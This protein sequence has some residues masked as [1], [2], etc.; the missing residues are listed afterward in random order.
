MGP[1]VQR[2]YEHL[3]ACELVSPCV[4]VSED[5]SGQLLGTIIGRT[6]DEASDLTSPRASVGMSET[7]LSVIAGLAPQRIRLVAL[8]LP[9]DEAPAPTSNSYGST[10]WQERDLCHRANV[11]IVD[12]QAKMQEISHYCMVIPTV[13]SP[14]GLPIVPSIDPAF[15]RDRPWLNVL[16]APEDRADDA[17]MAVPVSCSPAFPFHVAAALASLTAGWIGMAID[18]FDSWSESPLTTGTASQRRLVVMRSR[19]RS[20]V[21]PS[22]ADT[23]P[24]AAL[25]K[26]SS[27]PIPRGTTPAIAPAGIT[28]R[29]SEIF[30]EKPGSAF[31]VQ[32][33]DR[34]PAPK[35]KSIKWWQLFQIVWEWIRTRA[36]E[37]A[38]DAVRRK[39]NQ[40]KDSIEDRIQNLVFGENS[41][42]RLDNRG[43]FSGEDGEF[44]EYDI[45]ARLADI[46]GDDLLLRSQGINP[47]V[48]AA[49]REWSFGL[50]DGGNFA[51]EVV[52][53]L[54]D[55][56]RRIVVTDPAFISPSPDD[57]GWWSPP[58]AVARLLG[59]AALSI[60][61]CD[62]LTADSIDRYLRSVLAAMAEVSPDDVEASRVVAPSP[63]VVN[64]PIP[65]PTA[66]PIPGPP[67]AP[68][69]EIAPP[70]L[71]PAPPAPPTEVVASDPPPPPPPPPAPVAAA[72]DHP[73]TSTIEVAEPGSNGD[74]PPSGSITERG[75]TG[76]SGSPAVE[77]GPDVS[78]ASVASELNRRAS[79]EEIES[80]LTSLRALR[81]KRAQ[82]FHWQVS[83]RIVG[84]INSAS[85]AL[86]WCVEQ[87][88]NPPGEELEKEAARARKRMRRKL[89]W[90]I[91]RTVALIALGVVG[92]IFL[93]LTVLILAAL[94]VISV[95]SA[96]VNLFIGILKYFREHFRSDFEIQQAIGDFEFACTA[97]P[98]VLSELARLHSLYRQFLDWSELVGVMVHRPFGP[99]MVYSGRT[100]GTWVG[101]LFAHQVGEGE[102]SADNMAA[103]VSSQ[104]VEVFKPA[105]LQSVFQEASE[106]ILTR[107]RRMT[108]SEEMDSDPDTDNNVIGGGD[109][110]LDRS[111]RRFLLQTV[112]DGVALGEGRAGRMDEII[113]R[114]SEL[115]PGGLCD[116]VDGN[117]PEPWLGDAVPKEA[118]APFPGGL[119]IGEKKSD[120]PQVIHRVVWVPSGLASSTDADITVLPMQ[121]N[122]R[123][124]ASTIVCVDLSG[125]VD[126]EDFT[127][128]IRIFG[129]HPTPPVARV[130]VPPT[131]V[132]G[133]VRELIAF[134]G[135]GPDQSVLPVPG[136]II[137]PSG[138]PE[139]PATGGTFS[140]IFMVDG[141]PCRY[142]VGA[143]VNYRLRL[144]AGPTEGFALVRDALQLMANVSGLEFRFDG[145]FYEMTEVDFSARCLWI[146]FVNP[147]DGDAGGTHG[148]GDMVLGLGGPVINGRDIVGGSVR[149]G[150]DPSVKPGFGPGHTL[151]GV[152]LHE[153]GHALNLDHVDVQTELMFPCVTELSPD[154]FGPGDRMGLWLLGAGRGPY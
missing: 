81:T 97:V 83:E 130:P 47:A 96:I 20:L 60:R 140:Y 22:T 117:A 63:P 152:L 30:L 29:V 18:P 68:G 41:S 99:P 106:R 49:L 120:P 5:S 66:S 134:G 103:L 150:N 93:P 92:F 48:W 129:D 153:L 122:K 62:A 115:P 145:T 112:R 113:A 23:V 19:S 123:T 59:S 79:A 26:R 151:G 143:P 139:R 31:N 101:G 2:A 110:L 118:A 1:A 71:P 34:Q 105:W 33:P 37:V 100:H 10:D 121:S 39:I 109:P 38:V 126:C 9:G 12:N 70:P 144:G 146:A 43:R 114:L 57:F 13:D 6:A 149:I 78:A 75:A 148:L 28:T 127:N 15:L 85:G 131:V 73:P 61:P 51:P 104:A 7:L 135:S 87:L 76:T 82:S 56:P 35:P 102:I 64:S 116:S 42:L 128:G 138:S 8:V 80:A 67:S 14:D 88:N 119:W 46:G 3:V 125:L 45:T 94:L 142:P 124:L 25:S 36:R 4:W 137:S 50:I 108:T 58:V 107:Y 77:T 91:L 55:G 16:V 65:T 111:P 147:E 27:W 17:A 44:A 154:G 54:T 90:S 69:A 72:A 52:T 132:L 84:S 11:A 86:D 98:K 32:L 74:G 133:G 24:S 141:Q 95:A 89:V 40:A 53:L 136:S 21:V